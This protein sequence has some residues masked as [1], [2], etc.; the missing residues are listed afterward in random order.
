MSVAEI[1]RTPPYRE[2]FCR[3]KSQERKLRKGRGSY[4]RKPRRMWYTGS[5]KRENK[6]LN[7]Y[8]RKWIVRKDYEIK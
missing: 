1:V 7:S 3:V 8:L 5:F 6:L 4:R 2:S